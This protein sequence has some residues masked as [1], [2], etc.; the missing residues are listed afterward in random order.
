MILA[1]A[2]EAQRALE[3]WRASG[4]RTIARLDA[5]VNRECDTVAIADSETRRLIRREASRATYDWEVEG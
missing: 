1:R 4:P 5:L 3:W 2:P